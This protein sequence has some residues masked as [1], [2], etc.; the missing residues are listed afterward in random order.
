MRPATVRK[1][2]WAMLGPGERKGAY[3]VSSYLPAV[4]SLLAT[5]LSPAVATSAAA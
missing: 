2:L 4:G 3:G 5:G 1:L